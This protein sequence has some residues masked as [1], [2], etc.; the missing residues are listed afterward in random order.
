MLIN[1]FVDCK[2]IEW[3]RLLITVN[4]LIHKG[5]SYAPFITC[6]K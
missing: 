5:P 6:T 3:S 1:D 4:T 2:L